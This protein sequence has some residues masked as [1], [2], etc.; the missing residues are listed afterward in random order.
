MNSS[1]LALRSI[2]LLIALSA[3]VGCGGGNGLVG[4]GQGNP[5]FL[6]SITMTPVNPSITFT[7]SPEPPATTQFVVIGTY[8]VGNPKDITDQV[9]WTSLDSKVATVNSKGMATATGSGRVVIT[10]QIFEPANQKTL[11]ASTVFT[12]IPQLTGIQVSPATAQ[13][14]KNTSQQFTATGKYNDGTQ[15]DI[16]SLASWSSS[17]PVT[18]TASSSPGTHGRATAFSPGTAKISASLGSFA[19]SADL[20]VTSANLLSVSI[21]PAN[22]TVSLRG[23]QQLSALGTFDDG[24]SQDIST[25]V[26]WNSSD[27]RL[28]RV[29]STGT[30]SGVGIGQAQVTVATG[31]LSDTSNVTVD[32]S[33][34]LQVSVLPLSRIASGTR[35]QLHA[36]ATL[37]DGA[38]FEVSQTPGILWTSSNTAVANIASPNGVLTAAAPGAVTI[39]AELGTHT[40]STTLDVSDATIQ[41]LSVAPDPVAIAPGTTQNMIALATFSDGSGTFQQDVS[42]SAAWSSDNPTVATLSFAGRF[43][44]LAIANSTGVANLTASVADAHGNVAS[45]SSVF[46]VSSATLATISVVPGAA[47]LT[48]GGGQQFM[49]TGNFSDGTRQDLTLTANWSAADAAITDMDPYG[50]SIASGPGQTSVAAQLGS[51][52]GSGTV[53]VSP[54]VL[55]R[56]DICAVNVI[57]PLNNCPP[58]DPLLPPLPISFAKNVPFGLI[59]IGTFT[60]GSRENLTSSVRWSSSNA[61]FAAISNEPGVPGLS[62]GVARQGFVTGFVAGP[63]SISASTGGVSGSTDVIVTDFNPAFLTVAPT[64]SSIHPGLTQQLTATLTFGDSTTVD[65]TPY[66]AWTTSNPAAVIVY[67]GGLAYPSGIGI[68]TVTASFDSVQGSTTLTIQ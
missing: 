31:A 28:A 38:V 54:G 53:V 15:T 55:R 34:V 27:A 23:S 68:S 51:Q 8:S 2:G 52:T 3:I 63:V 14:A 25:T 57:D 64:A 36:V 37:Q 32:A 39:S 13:I 33:S 58:L 50:F 41:S 60:D 49:A 48:A 16:T 61:A 46:N 19:S 11:Q 9:T 45:S 18:A 67:P 12:V 59:A 7:V 1:Q 21:R 24:S 20:N 5:V 66:A 47:G 35:V 42:S 10:S 62:N 30:L 4:G 22:P 6:T 40:G 17:S 43:Q 29:T 26:F 44:E 56:T 65:V